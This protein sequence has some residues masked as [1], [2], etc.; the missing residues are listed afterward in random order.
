[1]ARNAAFYSDWMDH[2]GAV[3]LIGAEA[4]SIQVSSW[5]AIY[6]V[7]QRVISVSAVPIDRQSAHYLETKRRL[8]DDWSIDVLDSDVDLQASILS[9]LTVP[10][11]TRKEAQH[12]LSGMHQ[13]TSQGGF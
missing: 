10:A 3:V 1:M 13:S 12:E 6:P 5:N 11:T 2:H 8:G 9:Q 7:R 4:Y